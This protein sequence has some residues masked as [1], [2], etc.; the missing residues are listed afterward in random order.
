M[1][2]LQENIRGGFKELRRLHGIRANALW[3]LGYRNRA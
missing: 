2:S 3:L 1:Q